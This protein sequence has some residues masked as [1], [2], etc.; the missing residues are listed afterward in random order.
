MGSRK[1]QNQY[2]KNRSNKKIQYEHSIII[3]CRPTCIRSIMR[4]YED[5]RGQNQFNYVD[6][7]VVS[8]NNFLF[9]K[10]SKQNW[11]TSCAMLS[12]VSM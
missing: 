3:T 9:S 5:D 11:A 10:P 6:F 1:I 4:S 8:K 7:E 2:M 12:A